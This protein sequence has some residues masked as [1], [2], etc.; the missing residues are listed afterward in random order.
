MDNQ[1]D[2]VKSMISELRRTVS[3]PIL[4]KLNL[5]KCER[6]AEKLASFSSNCED[7]QVQL[8]E[9]ENQLNLKR[10]YRNNR[11]YKNKALPTINISHHF[12]S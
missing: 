9:L 6:V 12:S 2:H 8:L 1:T 10:R 7:C 11:R 5:N 3:E 4:K